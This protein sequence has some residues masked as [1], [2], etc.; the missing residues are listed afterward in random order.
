[1]VGKPIYYMECALSYA[2]VR[3]LSVK[4][5]WYIST[6]HPDNLNKE[7]QS[8]PEV[9]ADIIKMFFGKKALAFQKKKYKY[10]RIVVNDY[11]QIGETQK[12]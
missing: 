11:K 5:H 4:K 8:S 10:V 12:T 2:T 6:I 3:E 7:L 9:R 1:M